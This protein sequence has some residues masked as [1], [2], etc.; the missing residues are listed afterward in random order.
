MKAKLDANLPESLIGPLTALGHEIDNVRQ[1]DLKGGSDGEIWEA[2]QADTRLLVTQDLDFSDI[3]K[4]APGSH[5]GLLLLRLRLP[6]RRALAQRVLEILR[7]EELESW[8]RCFV[9]ATDRKIRV[10]RPK[11]LE[12][13]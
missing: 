3:R 4:F 8:A 2:A 1:E 9:V 12:R 6:G 11:G 13:S 5:Y 7:M 10:H